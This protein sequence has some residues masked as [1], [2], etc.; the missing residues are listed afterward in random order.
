M[1]FRAFA[2]FLLKIAAMMA[3]G[4][5]SFAPAHAQWQSVPASGP[6]AAP[7]SQ[8][9][10]EPAVE[11]VVEQGMSGSPACPAFPE[12]TVILDYGSRYAADSE[13]RSDLDAKA[14]EAV[15]KALADADNFVRQLA[16]LSN[17]AMI[18]PAIA[19]EN[20]GC[21]IDGIYDW[22]TA[23][24]FSQ[25][26]TE[27][28]E[29]TYPSRLAGVAAA[30]R[31]V[32]PLVTDR[33][34][35]K[36]T[37]ETWLQTNAEAMI[38][39]WNDDAPPRARVSNLR[40][41][42]A[43]AVTEAGLLLD[44]PDFLD[45]ASDSQSLILDTQLEDG[46]L[47]VEMRRGKYALHYQLHA[48]APL[49]VSRLLLCQAGH[50]AS[51]DDIARLRKGVEFALDGISDPERIAQIAGKQQSLP[52][53]LVNQQK[54]EIAFLEAYLSL[55]DDVPLDLKLRPL[56]PLSN[57]KLGGDLTMLY[58]FS[59]VSASSCIAADGP[60]PAAAVDE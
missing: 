35:E 13:D 25:L 46:S 45:W 43:F 40:A 24:A 5:A 19:A 21:V 4:V 32:R 44:E 33:A 39:Y 50:F 10:R 30:Y 6:V 17:A 59:G 1:G 52:S 12:P 29:L 14:D 15:T 53:G 3:L 56:R 41:W 9:S 20:A 11:P 26:D 48:L 60:P 54:F 47:P 42:A 16:D 23:G 8:T 22:A 57:S 49:T 7:V 31:Q 38:R 34:A 18:N 28:A 51:A 58:R 27:N 2:A 36:S 55:I 37:I